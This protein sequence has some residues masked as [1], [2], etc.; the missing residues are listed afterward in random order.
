MPG[1]GH[2]SWTRFDGLQGLTKWL[3]SRA[4][5]R[6]LCNRIAERGR[7]DEAR[8]CWNG[9]S[10]DDRVV[11]IGGAAAPD[12]LPV[13]ELTASSWVSRRRTSSSGI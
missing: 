5:W 8:D 4:R 13:A 6:A 7:D 10:P 2:M 3:M 11:G 12:I 9:R 1:F